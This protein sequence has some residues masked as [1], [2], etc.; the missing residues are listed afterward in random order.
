MIAGETRSIGHGLSDV[1]LIKTD[2]TGDT[3][4]TRTYGGA[5]DDVAYSVQQTYDGGYIVTGYTA[6]SGL[7]NWN[8]YLVRIDARGETL[9]TREYGSVGSTEYGMSVQQT[10][11]SGY[12]LTGAGYSQVF[13]IRTDPGGDT[14]WTRTYSNSPY[15]LAEGHSVRQTADGGYVIAGYISPWGPW[16]LW[17]IRINADGDRLW[18]KTLVD[19][20]SGTELGNSV[21]LTSHG[22][23][24][25]A[26]ATS[27]YGAGG[28]DVYLVRVD[29]DQVAVAEPKADAARAK[30]LSFDCEPNP[31]RSS[32]VVHLT[33][34]PLDRSTT[35]LGVYD[36]QGRLVH[37]TPGIRNSPFLLDLRSMPS[38][39]YFVRLDVGDKHATRRVVLQR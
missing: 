25:V 4:W 20:G 3:V 24:I 6:I 23:Y 19:T 2:A 12:I 39:T 35:L 10:T 13:T 5:Y 22:G 36:A 7:H 34:G 18:A 27:T 14:L 11:D 26:G 33:T 1:Y 15:D 16:D 30:G 37:S 28:A 8:V 17:L 31:C 38:G 29:S 32:T 9:W 21:H